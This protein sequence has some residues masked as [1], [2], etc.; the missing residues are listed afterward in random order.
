MTDGPLDPEDDRRHASVAVAVEH[1]HVDQIGAR[2][3]THELARRAGAVASDRASDV[4]PV[5]AGIR[6]QRWQRTG[7][8]HPR[9]KPI[10]GLGHICCTST[11]SIGATKDAA[12]ARGEVT[13]CGVLTASTNKLASARRS[14]ALCITKTNRAMTCLPTRP[15]EASIMAGCTPRD[16]Y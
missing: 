1:A 5:A 3:D 9:Q 13:T 6:H 10:R 8:V 12:A 11:G 7:Q 14:P 4:R 16:R 15:I 2:S